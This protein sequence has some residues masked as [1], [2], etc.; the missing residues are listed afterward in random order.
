MANGSRERSSGQSGLVRT[1]YTEF[2]RYCSIYISKIS[3]LSKVRSP[4]KMSTPCKITTHSKIS[5]H[6]KISN[7]SSLNNSSSISTHIFYVT[8]VLVFYHSKRFSC[9]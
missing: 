1:L 7:P 2:N 9:F 5:T 6:R 8:L 3:T 4:S